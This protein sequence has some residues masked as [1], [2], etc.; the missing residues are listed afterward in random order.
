[1]TDTGP[2]TSSPL[3]RTWLRITGRDRWTPL[4]ATID[5]REWISEAGSADSVGHWQVVYEYTVQGR[6]YVGQFADFA[7]E[8]QDYLRPGGRFEIRYNPRKP[9]QSYY[10]QVR[11]QTYFLIVCVVLGILFV[12]LMLIVAVGAFSR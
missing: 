5:S 8:D 1:M 2:R 7:P 9:S 10:P 6:R 4:Q 12:V 11:T 3:N